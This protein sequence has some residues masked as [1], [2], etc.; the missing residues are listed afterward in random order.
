MIVGEFPLRGAGGEPI[1][2]AHTIESHGIASLPPA[3]TGEDGTYRFALRLAGAPRRLTAS[4]RDGNLVVESTIRLSKR[5]AEDARIAIRRMFRLDDDLSPFYAAVA[6]DPDLAWVA[7]GAGRMLASPTAFEE[8]VKTICTTNCA[9]SGTIRMVGALVN[10]LGGGAFPSVEQMAEAPESWY[11]DTARAGYRGAY[12]RQLAR[13]VVSG[14]DLELLRPEC[15]LSDAECEERLLALPGVGPYAAAHV[16]QLIGRY[17]RLIFDSWTRPTYLRLSGK[18]RAKDSSIERAFRRYGN[19]AGL[20]FWL[21]LT[22][23]WHE[24]VVPTA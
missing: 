11:R 10:D 9:W 13:D 2:F 15:G 6:L 16:M 22:R 8:I 3:S 19:Y 14:L 7:V 4:A 17:H 12:L 1:S 18:K 20:A 23:H 5:A 21:Y 24:G